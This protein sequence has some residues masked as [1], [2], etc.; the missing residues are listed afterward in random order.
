[1]LTSGSPGAYPGLTLQKWA[2]FTLAGVGAP[3][4]RAGTGF[5]SIVRTGAGVFTV[6]FSGNMADA[7]YL[8]DL[9]VD[10]DQYGLAVASAKA[11][12]SFTLSLYDQAGAATDA[13]GAFYLGIY[14]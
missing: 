7:N 5:T 14:R 6:T 3:T 4:L 9:G 13:T 11:V 10:D 8:V 1:M 12:G 2:L